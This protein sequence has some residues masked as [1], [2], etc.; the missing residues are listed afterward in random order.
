MIAD[1]K[2]VLKHH[3]DKK[4]SSVPSETILGINTARNTN[5]DAFFKCIQKA[6]EVLTNAEKRRQFD[7]VD[8]E[9]LELEDHLTG[10]TEKEF[11]AKKLDFFKTFAP[12]YDLYMR[13]SRVQP[14]PGLGAIDATKDEVEGFYDFWYNFDSW[15]SFEWYDKE[16]NEGSDRCVH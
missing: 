16:V 8:P 14:V 3:P 2:K 12:I 13:F 10:I 5:D 7:S 15:R 4:A 11:K 9:F 6:H 1:R